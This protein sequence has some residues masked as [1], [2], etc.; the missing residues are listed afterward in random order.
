MSELKSVQSKMQVLLKNQ[1]EMQVQNR[2]LETQVE[3]ERRQRQQLEN[4]C[5]VK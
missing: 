3:A 1:H 5:Q 2:Q 4:K